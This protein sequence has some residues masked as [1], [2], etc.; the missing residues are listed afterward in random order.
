MDFPSSYPLH[1]LLSPT[2][3]AVV[4]PDDPALVGIEYTAQGFCGQSSGGSRLSNGL[5]Q[6]VGG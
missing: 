1:P 2:L 4:L 6:T 5:V 3:G